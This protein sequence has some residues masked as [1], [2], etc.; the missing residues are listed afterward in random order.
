[1]KNGKS[2]L[3]I[4]ALTAS[5]GFRASEAWAKDGILTSAKLGESNYCHLRFPAIDQKTLPLERPVLQD[6]ETGEIIDFYGPCDY[7]PHGKDAVQTQQKDLSRRWRF[8][9]GG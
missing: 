5:F 6:P 1:M 3:A 7:D 2:L 9:Y 4:I 8:E